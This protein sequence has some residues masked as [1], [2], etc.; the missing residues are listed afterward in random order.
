M[1]K[2]K[3]KKI[4][5]SVINDRCLTHYNFAVHIF[6]FSLHPCILHRPEMSDN[7]KIGFLSVTVPVSVMGKT[8]KNLQAWTR[9]SRATAG[10]HNVYQTAQNHQIQH[11]STATHDLIHIK[12]SIKPG[13]WARAHP[14]H[15]ETDGKMK[16]KKRRILDKISIQSIEKN[17]KYHHLHA[18]VM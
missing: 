1:N 9:G 8:I 15:K 11:T 2:K 16:N 6:I 4:P 5:P 17:L 3:K 18:M 14:F 13:I 10:T 7:S 12:Q